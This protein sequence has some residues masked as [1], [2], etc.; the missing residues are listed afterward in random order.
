MEKEEKKDWEEI[1]RALYEEWANR[2]AFLFTPTKDAA[3]TAAR[4]AAERAAKRAARDAEARA[5][6]RTGGYGSTYAAEAG[7]DAYAS[8]MDTLDDVIPS[9]YDL[10]YGRYKDEGDELYARLRVANE[11]AEREAKEE[12]E[13]AER[14]EAAKKEQ[15]EA[16]AKEQEEA[17]RA[18]EERKKRNA[19]LISSPLWPTGYHPDDVS[20]PTGDWYGFNEKEAVAVMLKAGVPDHVVE[21]LVPRADWSRHKSF[22]DR[23]GTKNPSV[24]GY[25][26]YEEYLCAYVN[27]ALG[28]TR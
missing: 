20:V 26:N 11:N 17:A 9:L 1:G 8:A 10:A 19:A 25:Q 23:D 22:N 3:Y 21:G 16:A 24:Y 5:A 13:A 18:E 15:E 7:N 28:M 6:A 4:D 12:K 2:P 14:E 27:G